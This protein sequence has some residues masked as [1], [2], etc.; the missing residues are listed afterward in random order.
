MLT[1]LSSLMAWNL[2]SNPTTVLNE[3]T[4]HLK[5]QTY[6]DP[7]YIFSGGGSRPPSTPLTVKPI[8]AMS[9][10]GS[11]IVL[12][13][14]TAAFRAA[15]VRM[16]RHAALQ[17][18]CIATVRS[19]REASRGMTDA[20]CAHCSASVISPRTLF[21]EY[22]LHPVSWTRTENTQK[23]CCDLLSLISSYLYSNRAFS[24]KD[25]IKI[26]SLLIEHVMRTLLQYWVR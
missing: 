24:E 5:G 11:G 7:Y 21:D 20:L 4:W 17:Q 6:S 23:P 8:G 12:S 2:Q 14:I 9:S 22:V 19:R 13:L 15:F 1:H 18:D 26:S 25:K 3:I 16:R 10:S